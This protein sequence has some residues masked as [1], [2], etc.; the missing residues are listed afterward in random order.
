MSEQPNKVVPCDIGV[1][2][3]PAHSSATLLQTEDF[4]YLM[5][6]AIRPK[7]DGQF[8]NAGTAIIELVGC[9]AVKFGAPT[10]ETLPGHPLYENGL[11]GHG[12][13][14]FEVLASSWV[15]HML[16]QRRVCF[17]E[18]RG[19]QGRHFVFTFHDGTLECVAFELRV[20]LSRE[21]IERIFEQLQ[22][23]V[24]RRMQRMR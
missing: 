9:G 18:E 6:N 12:C 2:P 4:A 16:A 24:F 23:R 7:P 15:R 19:G 21:P 3:E 22:K 5:F 13:A 14:V 20:K 8:E 11:K 1:I 10:E 17:P